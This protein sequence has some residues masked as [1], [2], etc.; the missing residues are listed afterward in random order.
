MPIL[1]R[2]DAEIYHQVSGEGPVILLTHGFG[3]DHNMWSPQIHL[4][5]SQFKVITWD[6][7]GHGQS[8]SP[9]ELSAYSEAET[10]QDM[11][12]LLDLVG[13]KTAIIGGMS[14]GGYMSL[15][16][17]AKYPER[18]L[19]LLLVDTGPGFKNDQAREDWNKV[20]IARGQEIEKNGKASFSARAEAVTA[21]HIDMQGVAQAARGMLTQKD[22]AVIH[23]LPEINVPTLV[24]VGANDLPYLVP[25]DYMAAKI[26]N[27]SKVTIRDAGHASNL[28]QP[29][30]FNRHLMSFLSK[31]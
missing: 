11:V 29:G 5:E 3:A 10:V 23:S 28:D 8:A 19:A 18:V 1:T 26:P 15:A 20:A 14:L 9:S 27:A 13:A 31:L 30:I 2:N 21:N 16:F 24:V 6:M 22:S 17:H 4:L 25:S 7:R 12:S